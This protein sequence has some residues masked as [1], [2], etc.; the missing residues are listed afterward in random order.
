[1]V[2]RVKLW[3]K[4]H[5]AMIKSKSSKNKVIAF[6]VPIIQ[7]LKVHSTVLIKISR[8]YM[9]LGDKIQKARKEVASA[10]IDGKIDCATSYISAY[11]K[12]N[13]HPFNGKA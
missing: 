13:A 6:L 9:T 10:D 11:K 1:M 8:N 12:E 3:A 5:E 7:Y 4:A 2:T